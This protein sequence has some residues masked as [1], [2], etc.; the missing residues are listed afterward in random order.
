MRLRTKIGAFIVAVLGCTLILQRCNKPV[1]FTG[2]T[3]IT[4]DGDTI[5]VHQKDKPDTKIF[6]PD[7]DTTIITTDKD[8]KVT[9]I[10]RQF[11]VGFDPG[12]GLG[13]SSRPRVALDARF[14]Y[15]KR[16]GA[17]AG[18]GLS[19]DKTDYRDGRILDIVSPYVG[20]S[21][22]PFTRFSNTS[23]VAAYAMDKHAFVFVR[24]RL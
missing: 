9:I 24:V 22:V 7:P 3:K 12:V 4:N 19:L 21:W 8:G 2:P 13:L 23:L 11:G 6:Q 10:V 5:V 20:V 1:T 16:F 18:L 14:V 17:N 15:F